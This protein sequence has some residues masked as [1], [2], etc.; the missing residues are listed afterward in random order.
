MKI[1]NAGKTVVVA[2]IVFI[3]WMIGLSLVTAGASRDVAFYDFV[4]NT[5]VS[6]EYESTIPL[7][8]YLFEPFVGFSMILSSEFMGILI[9]FLVAYPV[10]RVLYLVLSRGV[11]RGS[12]KAQIISMF[13]RNVMNFFFKYSLLVLGICA[14]ILGI[15]YAKIGFLFINHHSMSLIQAWVLISALLFIGKVV[16]NVIQLMHPA[17]RIRT[18]RRKKWKNRGT[19]SKSYWKHKPWEVLAREPKYLVCTIILVAISGYNLMS[20]QLPNQTFITSL[21]DGEILIDLHVHTTMSDGCLTPEERV[22]WYMTQ[23]I[24][25]AAFSDHQNTRGAQRAR[26]YVEDHG[27]DFLVITA[28]E[29]TT[30]DSPGMHMNVF[31]IEDNLTPIEFAGDGYANDSL[32]FNVSDAIH[33]AKMNGGFVIINHYSYGGPGSST[34]YTYAQLRDW[35]VDGFEI[36][37]A[38]RYYGDTLRTFCL[39]N[40]LSCLATTDEHFNR[41]ISSFMR[42]KLPDPSNITMESIFEQLRKNEH[43]AIAVNYMTHE[44]SINIPDKLDFLEDTVCIVEYFKNLN[45][46]Q[47]LSWHAWSIGGFVSFLIAVLYLKKKSARQIEAR[48]F[49]DRSKVCIF[50]K[51]K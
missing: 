18:K 16:Q 27:L 40:N 37:N 8:R 25:V 47:V 12:K 15:G 36:I 9:A 26:K 17:L 24:S 13:S 46:G 44:V 45:V 5:D 35:G 19:Q 50:L 30:Y 48:L 10:A 31:G 1:G 4:G 2:T 22:R 11:L 34:P 6:S 49:E 20:M 43:Q 33:Y 7:F 51:R 3:L 29:F 39:N 14:V 42:V 23:G 21:E 41:E 32:T 38:A 28:Q